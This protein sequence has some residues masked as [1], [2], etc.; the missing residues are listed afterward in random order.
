MLVTTQIWVILLIDCALQ[1]IWFDQPAVIPQMLFRVETSS[2]VANVCC[3]VR[4]SLS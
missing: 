2:V 3:F 1:G 4:L